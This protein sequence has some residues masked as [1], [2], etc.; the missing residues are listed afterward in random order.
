M[1]FK[2]NYMVLFCFLSC[3]HEYIKASS[4]LRQFITLYR[5]DLSQKVLFD[6][7]LQVMIHHA[8]SQKTKGYIGR[9]KNVI[10]HIMIHGY[11]DESFQIS[12][13]LK[14]K[15][16]DSQYISHA[17][18]SESWIVYRA[19]KRSEIL[20]EID[21]SIGYVSYNVQG[22]IVKE[23][24]HVTDAE[25]SKI[26]TCFD[27]S[28]LKKHKILTKTDGTSVRTDYHNNGTIMITG[29]DKK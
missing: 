26:M 16:L 12:Y 6:T 17:D 10:N 15:K 1:K 14:T 19:G 21:G 11:S 18:G 9:W 4:S 22:N 29:L 20:R 23:E 5:P 24:Q 7:C 8:D 13:Y 28:G 3:T 25:G 2:L 27:G